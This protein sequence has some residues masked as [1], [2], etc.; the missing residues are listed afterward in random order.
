[1]GTEPICPSLNLSLSPEETQ[2]GQCYVFTRVCDSVHGG[3]GGVLGLC[4]GGLHPRG[5]LCQRGLCPGGLCPGGLCQGGSLS[6]GSL[7]EGV[8][9]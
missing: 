8:S 2:L 3:G 4:P 9:A 6:G 5:V 1:M 7:S